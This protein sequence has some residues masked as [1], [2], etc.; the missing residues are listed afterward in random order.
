MNTEKQ[1]E[2]KKVC[3]SCGGELMETGNTY[4]DGSK[5]FACRI[6]GTTQ[7]G[8]I[9]ACNGQDCCCV[10]KPQKILI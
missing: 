1:E 6:C 10:C 3:F 5:V 7:P 9:D 8:M 4:A 2:K